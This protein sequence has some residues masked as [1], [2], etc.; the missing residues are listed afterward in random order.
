MWHFAYYW[1]SGAENTLDRDAQQL[2]GPTTDLYLDQGN[3]NVLF[4]NRHFFSHMHHGKESFVWPASVLFISACLCLSISVYLFPRSH[5][6]PLWLAPRS[7]LFLSYLLACVSRVFRLLRFLTLA[8]CLL[9]PQVLDLSLSRRALLPDILPLHLQLR[10]NW[11][12]HICL[13]RS[14]KTEEDK[15]TRQSQVLK[16]HGPSGFS[17]N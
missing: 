16:S 9:S 17:T 7:Y 5:A 4:L 14:L 12:E 11:A 13:R 3:H 10:L 1:A 2:V 8:L 6:P 15:K